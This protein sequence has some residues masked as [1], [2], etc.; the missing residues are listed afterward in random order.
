MQ[1]DNGLHGG[2]SAAEPWLPLAADFAI[3]N[4][5]A[6]ASDRHSMLS[7]YRALIAL[8]RSQAPLA[9]GD[10]VAVAASDAVLAYERRL[11]EQRLLVAL[12]LS[13]ATQELRDLPSPSRVLLSTGLD[14]GGETIAKALTLKADE[15][16]IA[17]I[18]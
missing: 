12:N 10:Y 17:R 3:V 4:V 7:L 16:I 14:R 9:I 18:G 8:R 1:W 2:F 5:A 15:G 11:G 13:G 6:Q